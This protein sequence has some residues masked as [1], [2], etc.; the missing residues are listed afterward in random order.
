MEMLVGA[1]ITAFLRAFVKSIVRGVVPA[2][3][4]LIAA[5]I[6]GVLYAVFLEDGRVGGFFASASGVAIG[7]LLALI[8]NGLARAQS[9][10]VRR[11]ML[12]G[13]VAVAAIGAFCALT[14][15]L[16]T[17]SALATGILFA[18][19]WG[20]MTAGVLGLVFFVREDLDRPA[21]GRVGMTTQ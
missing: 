12:A 6:A 20:G 10:E 14:G 9:D 16:V 1:L 19:T 3:L 7:V 17:G 21:D 8:V 13:S 15:Q 18:L 5:C 2:L 11:E 4:G